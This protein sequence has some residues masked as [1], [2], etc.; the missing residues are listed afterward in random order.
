MNR[1]PYGDNFR[2]NAQFNRMLEV[3]AQM[4]PNKTVKVAP[5]SYTRNG[6]EI[7]EYIGANTIEINAPATGAKWVLI[8]LSQNNTLSVI[9]GD[10]SLNSPP[11]PVITDTS[12]PLALIYYKA[13]DLVITDDMIYDVRPFFSIYFET[14]EKLSVVDF[15]TILNTT[16]TTLN[17]VINNKADMDGTNS[18]EFILNREETGALSADAL[19]S[20]N[21]G[22]ATKV[23]VKWNE[24]LDKW[25]YTND[26]ISFVDF[27]NSWDTAYATLTTI[28]NI[29][30]SSAP[31]NPLFPIAI[32]DNDHRLFTVLEKTNTLAH[33]ALV[34]A[35][36]HNTLS[37]LT[38]LNLPAHTHVLADLDAVTQGLISNAVQ[39][40]DARLFTV[41]E[42][43]N[44]L[45]HVA[46]VN[47][48]PHNT[49]SLLTALNLPHHSHVLADL[50]AAT[51]ALISNAV[52]TTDSRLFASAAE[53]NAVLAFVN[54]PPAPIPAQS[55]T[56]SELA[57]S[58]ISKLA[59]VDVNETIVGVYTFSPVFPHPPFFIGPNSVDQLVSGLNANKL[60]G[61]VA[62]DFV[63]V[64]DATNSIILTD[65]D[66]L[67]NKYKLEIRSGVLTIAPVV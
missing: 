32:G 10:S 33:V 57:P 6:N 56:F 15:N 34:N 28:G 13:N 18:S 27:G 62:A 2:R 39:T 17:N 22:S 66:I 29:A 9:N 12:I 65:L 52:Q 44:V 4:L 1:P 46:S 11:V 53:K 50:D 49:L 38:A 60:Q 19:L 61:K 30:I 43:G 58:L 41:L 45:T 36:P 26:G 48:D 31:V 35:D 37:L 20:V 8:S 47:A 24:D 23:S 42:K 3:H 40:T 67:T 64:N 25:Q 14:V 63:S 7:V 51:Q 59:E 21:R 16:V 54:A 55:I 5:G